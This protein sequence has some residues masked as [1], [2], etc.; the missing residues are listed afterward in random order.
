MKQTRRDKK[1]EVKATLAIDLKDSIY[2]LS[3]ITHTPIKDVCEYLCQAVIYEPKY[4]DVLHQYF[5]R[6]LITSSRNVKFGSRDNKRLAKRITATTERVTIKFKQIDYEVIFNLG[7]ALDV[8]ASRVVAIL[9]DLAMKDI[10]IVNLYI[11]QYLQHELTST[12][13]S[14][15]KTLLA[16]VNQSGEV[17][18]SWASLLSYI[19]DEIGSP[20]AKLRDTITK[21]LKN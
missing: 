12:Q 16:Y 1:K 17:Q 19:I 15:L 5:Q 7:Y 13:I 9:L 20:A 4:I 6:D 8:S 11:K 2:R 10:N 21:F 3:Y 18:H 14:E